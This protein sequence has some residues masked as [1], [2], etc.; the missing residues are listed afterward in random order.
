MDAYIAIVP[1]HMLYALQ[2]IKQKG[3][4]ECDLYYFRLTK[5]A[6]QLAER[7]R[8][9]HI[10]KNV[11]VL[12]N[13]VVE[14]PITIKQCIYISLKKYEAMSLLRGKHYDTVYYNSDGWLFNSII[15]T[16]LRDKHAKN[17][18]V[19]NG[20]NPYITPYDTKEWYLRLFIKLNL[21]T[22]MDGKYID[23]R[24]VFEPSLI[25][26]PQSGK[27]HRIEKIDCSDMEMLERVNQIYGYDSQLDSFESSDFIILEQGPRR[28]P[29]DM[30]ALWS[31][32]LQIIDPA[33]SI[34]KAHPRQK[35]SALKQLGLR[36]FERYTTPWE[37]LS[38]N[39]NME[40]KTILAIFS[41][42]C[43]NPK[44]MFG[45]E[46][47][48]IMLYKL[49]GMDYSFFG[50]GMIDFVNGVGALYKDKS[51]F[52]IPETWDEIRMYYNT[53]MK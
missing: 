18:F 19:E 6:D 23:E 14:Y 7:V 29:I 4:K 33:R 50:K 25:S 47:R 26:V 1:Q 21:L 8:E 9:Q 34:V 38:M 51:R 42:A 11:Y 53:Y 13:L 10:F 22:C 2:M 5:D 37:V 36:M 43:V 48:V 32:V 24:Y 17:V 3:I 52:F 45:Q 27:I 31:N 41:T 30:Y 49:I 46:P 15:Y 39:Q 20:L 40:E 44:L 28:E 35:E 12:P 16:G